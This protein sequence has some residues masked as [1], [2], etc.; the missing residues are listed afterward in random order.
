M[1][2]MSPSESLSLCS[3]DGVIIK[4]SGSV[5]LK[6]LGSREHDGK[7]MSQWPWSCD[8]YQVMILNRKCKFPRLCKQ[9]TTFHR[10][11]V[12][13]QDHPSSVRSLH[14]QTLLPRPTKLGMLS[15]TL[16]GMR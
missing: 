15:M 6:S 16:E 7:S 1:H 9:F 11:L 4:V 2:Y 10:M 8:V 3:G 13:I 12:V 14:F 5:H